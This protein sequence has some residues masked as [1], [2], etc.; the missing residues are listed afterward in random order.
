MLT[1]IDD[2]DAAARTALE[3]KIPPELEIKDQLSVVLKEYDSIRKQVDQGS[4]FMQSLVIP[5]S[6]A[7]AGAMIGW[8][9]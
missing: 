5:I 1:M 3:N 2:M 7:I 9:K 8:Q 4:A 6:V